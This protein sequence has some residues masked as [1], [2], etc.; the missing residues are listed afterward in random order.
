MAVCYY[1]YN[2]WVCDSDNPKNYKSQSD[3]FKEGDTVTV[4]VELDR[5]LV[6]WR[7]NGDRSAQVFCENLRNRCFSFVPYIEMYEKSDAVKWSGDW[8]NDKVH[9]LSVI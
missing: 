1:G 7:V 2:G 4:A 3:G 5:G 8:T 9:R 6:E